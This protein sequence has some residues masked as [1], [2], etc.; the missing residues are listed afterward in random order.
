MNHDTA[1]SASALFLHGGPGLCTAMERQVYADRLPVIWWDQPRD[2]RTYEALV[3]ACAARLR[4][5]VEQTGRPVPLLASSFAA[6]LALDLSR[7]FQNEIASVTL[8]AGLPDLPRAFEQMA[9]FL[10]RSHRLGSLEAPLQAFQTQRSSREALWGLIGALASLPNY[11][12]YIW[13]PSSASV[14]DQVRPVTQTADFMDGAVFQSVLD[15]F[16][17]RPPPTLPI[18]YRGPVTV[19]TG[20]FDPYADLEADE[21]AWRTQFPSAKCVRLETGH[22]PHLEASPA[23]WLN[24]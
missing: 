4:A 19:I 1:S 6:H 3:A 21:S 8:L 23:L 18:S 17:D 20:T 14:R 13:A 24:L 5:A 7:T 12:D 2:R 11:L 9:L 22:L 15:S 10:I 16:L